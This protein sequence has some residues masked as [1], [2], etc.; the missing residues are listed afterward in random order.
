MSVESDM[1]AY[2]GSDWPCRL[3]KDVQVEEG[4][5]K[6]R[7]LVIKCDENDNFPYCGEYLS[8]NHG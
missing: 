1:V 5:P 7:D 2:T 8:V 4:R 3:R 6:K